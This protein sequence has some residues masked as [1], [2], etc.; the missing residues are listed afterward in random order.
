V[1]LS[2][3]R[4]NDHDAK[5]FIIYIEGDVLKVKYS[6]RYFIRKEGDNVPDQSVQLKSSV[7]KGKWSHIALVMNRDG[8]AKLFINGEKVAEKLMDIKESGSGLNSMLNL[9]LFSDA[10]GMKTMQGA[11]DELR[12][13]GKALN[14]NEVTQLTKTAGVIKG[15]KAYFPFDSKST[16]ELTEYFTGQQLKVSGMVQIEGGVVNQ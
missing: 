15:L 12:I 11:L 9:T 1:I 10:F 13:H 3:R 16:Q 14:D 2:N 6:T 5:G 7:T 8:M 4:F